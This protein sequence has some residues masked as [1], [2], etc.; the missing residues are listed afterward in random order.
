MHGVDPTLQCFEYP[1]SI[2]TAGR[3]VA[4]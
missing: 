3:D 2:L 4:M 1:G